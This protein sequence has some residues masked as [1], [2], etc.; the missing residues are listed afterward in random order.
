MKYLLTLALLLSALG[1]SETDD[2]IPKIATVKIEFT[3]PT[4]PPPPEVDGPFCKTGDIIQ[5]GESCF[6]PGTDIQIF[7]LDNGAL[8]MLNQ[9]LDVRQISKINTSINGTLITLIAHRRNDNSWKIDKVRDTRDN[10]LDVIISTDFTKKKKQIQEDYPEYHPL[11]GATRTR[12]EVT[13]NTKHE[14]ALTESFNQDFNLEPYAGPR[15]RLAVAIRN[16]T[17]DDELSVRRTVLIDGVVE[18]DERLSLGSIGVYYFFWNKIGDRTETETSTDFSLPETPDTVEDADFEPEPV[19]EE[20]CDDKPVELPGVAEGAAEWRTRIIEY[21]DI[22]VL[23]IMTATK[24]LCI[25]IADRKPAFC[26]SLN[27]EEINS[28]WV[29]MDTNYRRT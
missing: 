27:H 2:E 28:S 19:A 26:V 21:G 4:P 24:A 17:H 22:P 5:P 15:T 25:Q 11:H 13:Y 18:S 7:V 9:Y 23:N 29:Y 16:N 12:D 14:F 8:Y 3:L 10:K 20:V 6:Y 1:C